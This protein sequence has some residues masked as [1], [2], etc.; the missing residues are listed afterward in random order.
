[1]SESTW[2]AIHYTSIVFVIFCFGVILGAYLISRRDEKLFKSFADVLTNDQK[3][4]IINKTLN[5]KL[6]P[7]ENKKDK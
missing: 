7:N 6:R 1:M 4:D 2:W 5:A 3:D